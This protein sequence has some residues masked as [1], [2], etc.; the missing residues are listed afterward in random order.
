MQRLDPEKP[1]RIGWRM[2]AGISAALVLAAAV[3]AGLRKRGAPTATTQAEEEEPAPPL[4]EQA[5][6]DAAR[7]S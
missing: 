1:K 3:V 4:A 5:T 7:I 6:A 2:V